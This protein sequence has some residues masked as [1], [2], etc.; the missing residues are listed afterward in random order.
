MSKSRIDELYNAINENEAFENLENADTPLRRQRGLKRM[1]SQGL[2]PLT[3]A[4]RFKAQFDLTIKSNVVSTPGIAALKFPVFLFGQSDFEGAFKGGYSFLPNI[5]GFTLTNI[6]IL[7]ATGIIPNGDIGDLVF[8]YI[9]GTTTINILIHCQQVAYGTLLAA[10]SSDTFIT[11]LIR[12]ALPSTVNVLQY[13]E[14]VTIF[15]QSLFGKTERD[16]FNP[17]SYKNPNQQQPNIIDIPVG[18]TINKR[19]ELGLYIETPAV[20]AGLTAQ[21]DHFSWSIFVEA[22]RKL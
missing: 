4:P 1:V 5:S 3:G 2:A 16:S 14:S 9:S 7:D 17:N 13:N 15:K 19:T 22:D 10:T 21:T 12:Y 11:N 6:R 18:I 20:G 8:T